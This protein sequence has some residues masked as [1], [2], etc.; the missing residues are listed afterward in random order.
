MKTVLAAIDDSPA[1]AGVLT[2]AAAF[3][4]LLDGTVRAIRVGGPLAPTLAARSS[5][6]TPVTVIAGEPVE[7]IIRAVGQ[8][9]VALVVLGA[10]RSPTDER[11]VGHVARAVLE[12]AR[13]PVLVTPIVEGAAR[14]GPIDR[15][16]IPLEGTDQT[17]EAVTGAL[18][19]LIGA[20]VQPIAIHVF[21]ESTV[22]RFWDQPLHAAESY[23]SAFLSRWC[24]EAGVDLR[25][26]RGAAADE[27]V[28]AAVTEGVDVIALVWSRDLGPGRADVVRAALVHAGVPVLLIPAKQAS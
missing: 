18:H 13:K 24:T 14:C 5:D 10:T 1:A 22:P 26:R 7:E 15:A 11:P 4:Q 28:R 25:L 12:S 6:A 19:D 23:A 9:D 2:T 17:S 21:D 27:V 16:L 20:G 8:P 3:A